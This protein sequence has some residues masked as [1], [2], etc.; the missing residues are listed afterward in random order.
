MRGGYVHDIPSTYVWRIR[1]LAPRCAEVVVVVVAHV[2]VAQVVVVVAQG[3]EV[4]AGQVDGQAALVYLLAPASR[5]VS[6]L[7]NPSSCRFC[8]THS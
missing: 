2:V 5:L 8:A 3:L 7:R 4:V 1:P 6:L